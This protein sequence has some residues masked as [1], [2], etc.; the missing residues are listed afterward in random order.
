MNNLKI[1]AIIISTFI[2]ALATSFVLD[3][4]PFAENPVKYMLVVLFILVELYF[5]YLVYNLVTTSEE[6]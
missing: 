6:K 3:F 4:I 2:I 1:I 5:G